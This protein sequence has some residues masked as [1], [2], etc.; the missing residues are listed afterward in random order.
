MI[1]PIITAFT[2]LGGPI[3]LYTSTHARQEVVFKEREEEQDAH[4]VTVRGTISAVSTNAFTI[5]EYTIYIDP[6]KTGSFRQMGTIAID[7]RAEVKARRMDGILYAEQVV[8]VGTGQG[9][10]QI[11]LTADHKSEKVHD[12]ENE[13]EK[14][15]IRIKTKG[16]LEQLALYL[17]NALKLFASVSI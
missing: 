2:P 8:I 11:V 3:Q 4:K 16:T 14:V 7:A 13:Q 17:K 1:I 12:N 10:T 15:D 9:R 6:A 5:G